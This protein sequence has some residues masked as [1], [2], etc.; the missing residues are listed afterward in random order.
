MPAPVYGDWSKRLPEGSAFKRMTD[1][2]NPWPER[3]SEET[4]TDVRRAY[5]ACITQ[6]D[7]NLG[8]LFARLREMGLFENTWI[9]FTSDHGEFLGDH[10]LGSKM[11]PLEA[12]AHIPFIIMPPPCASMHAL[13][14]T[15]HE[16]LV[17]L[18][19]LLPTFASISNAGLPDAP[20]D[21]IDIISVVNGK[22]PARERVFFQC[23]ELHGLLDGHWKYAFADTTEEQLL[24]DLE[25]DP[26]EVHDL[27]QEPEHRARLDHM[28]GLLLN[29]LK[30]S[31]HPSV[32]SGE[33]IRM[34]EIRRERGN[35]PG[36]HS[37]HVTS[38][39]LH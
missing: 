3:F 4:L 30:A 10:G 29:H 5:Y 28:H 36:H 9:V 13:R 2:L 1:E 16:A 33:F 12:S 18:A 37:T 38:D 39:V 27:S 23:Q 14:G 35:W 31:G 22:S 11:L 6:I 7:Y 19:D 20:I 26:E 15:T 17:T 34:P 25:S 24:F 21:G 8:T 32:E